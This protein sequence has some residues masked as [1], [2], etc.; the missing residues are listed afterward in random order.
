MCAWKLREGRRS[1]SPP[2]FG[3]PVPRTASDILETPSKVSVGILAARL[4]QTWRHYRKAD[5]W[6]HVP[7]LPVVLI[8][9]IPLHPIVFPSGEQ[10]VVEVGEQEGKPRHEADRALTG[11]GLLDQAVDLGCP[12]AHSSSTMAK[13]HSVM[14]VQLTCSELTR[15]SKATSHSELWPPRD[16]A[17]ATLGA[18]DTMARRTCHPAAC[19]GSE[20]CVSGRAQ[21]G[22]KV[23]LG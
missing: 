17:A 15:L 2:H 18:E 4:G 9:C 13:T 23:S 8:H 16:P 10:A 11:Q 12:W 14:F 19:G 5:G 1:V 22:G 6:P 20:G 21:I 7:H 3:F